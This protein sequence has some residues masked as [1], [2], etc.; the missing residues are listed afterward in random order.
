MRNYSSPAATLSP[1]S[2]RNSTFPM[3]CAGDRLHIQRHLAQFQLSKIQRTMK[4]FI[5]KKAFLIPA[6][7]LLIFLIYMGVYSSI[8]KLTTTHINETLS[9]AIAV[10]SVLL[11]IFF[12][13]IYK[14]IGQKS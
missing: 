6:R 4:I 1:K 12:S 10:I 5:N 14:Q 9:I 3:K 2:V 11:E 13:T 7:M 8:E